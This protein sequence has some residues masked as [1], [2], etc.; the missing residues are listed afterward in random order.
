MKIDTVE[1]LKQVRKYQGA[2]KKVAAKSHPDQQPWIE[3]ICILGHPPLPAHEAEQNEKL[4]RDVNARYITYDQL[5]R[6]T[7]DSYRDYLQANKEISRI[8][9][10]IQKL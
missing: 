3:T 4:L 5:I 9:E 8:G 6:Q 7:R 1:L 10:L 2:V